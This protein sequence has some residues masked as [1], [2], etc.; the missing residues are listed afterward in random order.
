[1]KELT[2][3]ILFILF[4]GVS[5][6]CY[7]QQTG[8]VFADLQNND[9]ISTLRQRLALNINEG[10][11]EENKFTN[12]RKSFIDIKTFQECRIGKVLS[13]NFSYGTD[14]PLFDSTSKSNPAL[15]EMTNF[16]SKFLNEIN[17]KT[18]EIKLRL[19]KQTEKYLQK[20]KKQ[21]LKLKKRMFELDSN[22]T[23]NLFLSNPDKQYSNYL[24]KLKTD[25]M[26]D[27]GKITGEYLPYADSLQ[28]VL[29]FMNKNPQ[30]FRSSD[31]NS[32]E[33]QNSFNEFQKLQAK[34][35]DADEITGYIR[36]RKEQIKQYLLQFAH[37]PWSIT[38]I[39][40][41]YTKQLYY[42]DEQV[43]QFKESLNNPDKLLQKG[44]VFLNKLPFFQNFMKNNSILASLL[45]NSD[46]YEFAQTISGL[47]TR[48]QIFQII[49][50]HLTGPN[51]MAAFSQNVSEAEDQLNQLKAKVMNYGNAGG[52]V[53]LPNFKPSETKNKPFLQRLEYGVNF[54]SQHANF[55]FPTTTDL[56]L[57]VGYKLK[58]NLLGIGAS[59]K[60]GWGS[61]LNHVNISSQG[62]GLRS[63]LDMKI[64][65]SFYASGGFEYNYQKP[66]YTTSIFN[67]FQNWEKSGLIGVSK[68][69]SQNNKVFKKT[70]IQL[71]WDFLSY[72]QNPR[73]QPLKFRIGY[74]F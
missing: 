20:L 27:A 26:F 36:Q 67:E 22:A 66:F 55:Y 7:C 2:V 63:Y 54:Q 23:K 32:T 73:S 45:P 46:N 47:Q 25:S 6:C 60:I 12:F 34:M 74:N 16:P 56:G 42:Y 59:Y 39:Y 14:C 10:V 1:M 41:D 11:P 37:V 3:L 38:K 21:E 48:D 15:D 5:E 13:N 52:D 35:Q 18:N 24:Q 65:K 29:L 72:E 69:V 44:L 71:L 4:I 17:K 51:A 8:D 62:V 50:A 64:K 61:S 9:R 49:Q 43:N 19:Q 31:L 70:K 33:L 68:I 57:T 30:L 53:D 40:T 28:G 58:E